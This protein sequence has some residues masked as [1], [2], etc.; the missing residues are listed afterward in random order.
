MPIQ[1]ITNDWKFIF[2]ANNTSSFPVINIP[3]SINNILIIYTN[4][5]VSSGS[6]F[7]RAQLSTNNG[8]SYITTGYFSGQTYFQTG[9]TVANAQS[10]TDGIQI[11]FQIGIGSY[12]SGTCYL[13]NLNTAF[14]VTS[15]GNTCWTS[16]AT[17]TLYGFSGGQLTTPFNINSFQIAMSSGTLFTGSFKIY[18]LN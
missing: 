17:S 16:G 13:Y 6:P 5:S 11:G 3:S 2:T 4:C 14:P 7:M 9:G 10:I 1:N 18:G 12:S 8:A 15:T